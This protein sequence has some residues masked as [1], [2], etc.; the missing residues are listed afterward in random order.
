MLGET[1]NAVEFYD[2]AIKG[3]KENRYVQD[4]ALANELAAEFYIELGWERIAKI[5]LHEAASAYTKWGATG[6]VNQLYDRYQNYISRDSSPKVDRAERFELQFSMDAVSEDLDISS[7]EIASATLSQELELS[8]VLEKVIRILLL[9]ASAQRC[10][11][12]HINEGQI[13]LEA[14][15]TVD[16]DA[17]QTLQMIPIDIGENFSRNIVRYV[18]NTRE[19]VVIGDAVCDERFAATPYVVREKPKSILCAPIFRSGKLV[20]ILYMENNLI[21]DAFNKDRLAAIQ[22]ISTQAAI[23]LEN[24]HLL[25]SLKQ[26]ISTRCQTEDKLRQALHEVAQLKDKLHAEN[27]YLQKEIQNIQGIQGFNEIVGNSNELRKVL[28]LV[29]QVAPTDTTVLILGETGTGKELIASAIHKVSQRSERVLVKVNCASLPANLIESELFGHEKGAFTGAI[30]TKLGRFELADGGTLFL[31]EIGELPIDLQ[32]KLLRVLQEGEIDRIGSTRTIKVNVRLIAATNRDL[33]IEVEKGTF[34]S[35]LY[36]RLNV[37]P[38]NLPP[39]RTIREDIPLLVW[40]FIKKK[41]DKFGKSISNISDNAMNS[42]I[43]YQWPGN[44]RELENV[45]ERALILSQGSTLTLDDTFGLTKSEQI[46]EP[47]IDHLDEIERNHI[48]RILDQCGWQVKGKGKAAEKLGMTPGTLY[49]K[50]KTLGLKPGPL[51]V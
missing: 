9:N 16:D 50:I 48:I 26:E 31:D 2:K 29:S 15:G 40:S 1:V 41:Q 32:A 45:V 13:L 20:N 46:S 10:L 42:F 43:H 4:E 25:E 7:I 34:R 14:S 36:Y 47:A 12:F 21:R 22:I 37:F 35:D 27:K 18:S 49:Y 44:I 24:S 6:K 5:Y 19:T 38:I 51:G 28:S 3:A 11:L 39:L 30:A 33:K 23:A 17:V 8:K